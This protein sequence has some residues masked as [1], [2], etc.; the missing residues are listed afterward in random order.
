LTDSPYILSSYHFPPLVSMEFMIIPLPQP[1]KFLD[2]KI[3]TP[4]IHF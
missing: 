4:N 2:Y 1:L 3:L